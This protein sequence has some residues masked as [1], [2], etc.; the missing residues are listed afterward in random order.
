MRWK[1]VFPGAVLFFL[2]ISA[3]PAG[4]FPCSICRCGDPVFYIS[5]ARSLNRGQWVFTIDNFYTRKSSG[6][7]ETN[8]E[9][10]P[11]LANSVEVMSLQRALHGDTGEESQHQNTLELVLNY[12]L[13]GRMQVMATLPYLFNRLSSSEETV[14]CN[15][16]GDPELTFIVHALSLFGDRL[17]LALSGGARLPL[18]SASTKNDDGEILDQ[19]AQAGTGA[20]AGTWG[21]QFIFGRQSLPLFFSTSYQVSGAN[22][23]HFRYG[24]VWRY[25][26]ALQYGLGAAVDLIGEV[27]GRYSRRD[28]DGDA[29]DPNTGGTVVYLSPGLRVNLTGTVAL[30]V[31]SQIPVV[32]DLY[33]LQHEK[34][35]FLAGLIW[36]R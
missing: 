9:D 12:G 22:G 25:N 28:Q 31:Q 27:N 10:L 1:G 8:T 26:F 20:W 18:G 14:K 34:Y 29:H 3:F 21:V 33:G 7:R 32:D 6:V 30:R 15:G 4:T 19:H 13:S 35:N 36:T 2:L 24:N 5:G 23:R 17:A 11:A 16:F